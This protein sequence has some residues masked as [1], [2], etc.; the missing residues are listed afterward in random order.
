[1]RHGVINVI[2]T[3]IWNEEVM[4]FRSF[5]V[6][7]TRLIKRLIFNTI[8]MS[9]QRHYVMNNIITKLQ[10]LVWVKKKLKWI[11]YELNKFLDLFLY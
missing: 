4:D 5:H 11:S 3:C 8:F 9:N 10:E 2:T 6:F 7:D 1:M